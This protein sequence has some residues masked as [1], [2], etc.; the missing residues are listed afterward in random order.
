MITYQ[1]KNIKIHYQINV[2][3]DVSVYEKLIRT[4]RDFSFLIS[5]ET[6]KMSQ[7]NFICVVAFLLLL[8]FI[9]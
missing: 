5:N 3:I 2:Q 6:I 1:L 7:K 4:G 8:F 9:F